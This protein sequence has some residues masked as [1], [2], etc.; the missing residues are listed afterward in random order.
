MSITKDALIH[1]CQFQG[2]NQLLII[3]K[4]TAVLLLMGSLHLSAASYSQT[5]TLEAK[6]Y[7]LREV[8]KAIQ[9]Q[10]DY[11]VI[12]N[13]R[14]LEGTKPVDVSAKEMPL[15]TFL[16]NVLH[17]QALIYTISEKTILI[18][19]VKQ[20]L[21]SAPS[22]SVEAAR[23]ERIVTGKVTDKSGKPLEG[24]TVTVKGATTVVT[25]DSDGNYQ[26][27]VPQD[28][29][30]LV[31]TIVGFEAAEYTI[32]SQRAINVSLEASV[33]D[34]DEVVVVGYGTQK[35]E[36][37]TGAISSVQGKKLVESP[38]TN[39]TH[40]LA[41]RLPGVTTV[42]R[43]GEPG[44]DGATIRIRGTNTL[45]DNGALIVVDGIP[46]RSLD[47]IDP[48]SIESLTVLKDASAAIYGSQAANGV[49]LVTTKRGQI[50]RPR[51]TLNA[52]V[53][54]NQPTV[55]PSLTNAA[56]YA[57]ALNELDVYKNRTPRYTDD[58]IELFRNGSD[59]WKYPN[60]DWF[61][62]T[63]ENWAGQS[64]LNM[65]VA[66]GGEFVRYYLAGGSRTQNGIYRNSATRYNQYDFRSNIDI[67]INRYLKLSANL[68]G[69][70]EDRN[71]PM[72]NNGVSDIFR[73]LVRGKPNTPAYWPNGLPGPDIEYGSNPV[74]ITTDQTG[75]NSDKRYNLNSNFSLQFKVPWIEGLSLTSNIGWDKGFRFQKQFQKPW[76][77]Y[78]W[79]GQ[80]Y[81]EGGTPLLTAGKK[82]VDD[83]NLTQYFSTDYDFL[84]NGLIDYQANLTD[85]HQLK[86]LVG[87]ET[88]KGRND[89]FEAYRRYFAS[90]VIDQLDAGGTSEMRNE[91]NASHYARMNYFGRINYDFASKYLVEF[92]WR[93][94]GSYIF[95][96]NRRYGFFPGM[97]LGWV[98]SEEDFWKENVGLINHLKLRGSYGQTGNDRITEW[99][100]LTTYGFASNVQNQVFDVDNEQKSLYEL[101]I[102][103]PMV[104]WEKANQAD[105]GID[106]SFWSGKLA[107]TFDYFD[108][109][110]S[111]ILWNRNASI[112]RSTGLTLPREN[113]GSV[114]NKGYDFNVTFHHQQDVLVYSIS[115][116][117]GYAKNKIT[118]WDEAP[119]A[120]VYQQST[121]RPIPTNPNSVNNDLYYQVIGIFRD[122]AALESYPHWPGARTGDPIFKDVNGDGEINGNDRVRSEETNIPTFQGGIGFNLAYRQWYLSAL[123][124]GASGG[125]RYIQTES[126]DLGNYLK[127]DFDGR[128]TSDN[129]D[130]S[131]PRIYNRNED[132]WTTNRNTFY[133]FS[134]DYV[135]L[136]NLELGYHF[137][138]KWI[139]KW[140]VNALRLYISGY[141]LLT[142]CPDLTDFDPEGSDERG[143]N[144]PLSRILNFGC[145]LTF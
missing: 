48:N 76:Y 97:S 139:G 68:Y 143:L 128:W 135:R 115:L 56:E 4:L 109:R 14:F 58:E 13:V 100:Y 132:Y 1:R 22:L 62:E 51:L 145:S 112:P 59:P 71:Q 40:T 134:T 44:N 29:K 27:N 118:F 119:G 9:K 86:L 95:P 21:R 91:G 84:F 82:G 73:M 79:D 38:V 50:G 127:R 144:Y 111:N 110:R 85:R 125:V 37:L 8:F 113:I 55:L 53:G 46:G 54:L 32:G 87:I 60:T 28:G 15:D 75:Y 117:G 23:Q 137:P 47:R 6:D 102:P 5:I 16:D 80:S 34:L 81:D 17:D 94:D 124:Q 24:V 43:G 63:F 140:G 52:N 90:T 136:K 61:E 133:L 64:N 114:Q 42:T 25:T 39:T 83:P 57:I 67:N 101:R 121:G 138:D 93:L 31:F 26:I 120:P 88:R 105:L 41:G 19:K 123:V 141:N 11:K 77:L 103:N 99:Q 70:L 78:S 10:T 107:L 89:Y 45:G 98:V 69:R 108:Y 72:G 18:G 104:T 126:G 122:E 36:T 7:S 96:A 130:A 49:I 30:A 74:V 66:G 92:I 131:K 2:I 129:P 35:K 3:M 65:D 33:S 142:Y 106:A 116:N 12:Y 20:K